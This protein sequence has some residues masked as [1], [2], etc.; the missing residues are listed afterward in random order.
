MKGR[1]MAERDERTKVRERIE[2]LRRLIHYHDYRYYVL[3]Q[4]EISDAE[5]DRLF[6]ELRALEEKYPELITPDSPT[7]RVGGKVAEGFASVEHKVAMLSLDNAYSAEDLREFE[8]R[9]R[10]LLPGEAIEYVTEPKID[11]LGVALLYEKGVL[12]RGATRGDG[13]VG[14]D[15]TNNLKTIRTIPLVL[16]GGL[17]GLKVLEVRGEVYM[18]RKAFE[19]LNRQLEEAGEPTFANPRN[20][21][22]GSVRQKDSSITA[23]RPLDIFIYQVSYAEP[24]PFRTHWESLLELKEGGFKV[25][26]LARLCRDMEAVIQ[27][28]RELEVKRE[29]L[30][31][32]ADGVVVKVND[33]DQQRRLG[34]TTHHPRWAIA[35]KF[36]ARQAITKVLSIEVQVGKTGALTPVAHLQPVE[37]GGVTVSRASL[38][39]EDEVLRKDVRI[40]D[41]VVV[42]RAGDVIPQVVQVILERRSPDV[43]KFVMPRTCPACGAAAFRPEGEAVTRCTNASCPAQLKERLLHFGSRRAMDIEHLGE[44][45]VEQLVEKGLVRDLADLYHLDV[46]TLAGLERMA[47]KSAQNLYQAIQGSKGKGF[48]R[49][50]YALGIRYIGEKAARVL[51]Q[52]Y[53]SMDRLLKADEAEIA[54]IYGIGPTIASSL[55]QW[56]TQKENLRLLDRLREVGVKMEEEEGLGERILA[57]KTFVFTGALEGFTR[58]EAQELVMR[59]GGRVTSSVSKKTDYLVVG[60]DPGSKYDEAKR[61]GVKIL[62]EEGFK[63]L[64][65]L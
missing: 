49:L 10:R 37:V 3:N 26:P 17:K 60:K 44:A 35:Y 1:G 14:E 54:G 39:N 11:G 31:Y 51:A 36:P 32:D 38:H 50:L 42:E 20:A 7:Q 52:H 43:K 59:L 9:I 64:V 62:D 45:I 2:E 4:P 19:R 6:R 47:E 53:R 46:E 29:T 58:D 55:R 41:W 23:R 5:Y 40:G 24:F 56:L 34:A 15:V 61:L 18:G 27:S 16:R 12:V 30:D 8:Q 63:K 65:G 22:A 57:G 13:R 48:S 25:N 33:L 28:C 21:A